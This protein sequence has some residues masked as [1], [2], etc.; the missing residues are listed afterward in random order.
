MTC[1]YNPHTANGS[2]Y[3]L[4]QCAFYAINST[5][6]KIGN[7]LKTIQWRDAPAT[8]SFI[9]TQ[10]DAIN[11]I[12]ASMHIKLHHPSLPDRQ[13]LLAT[14]VAAGTDR[15]YLKMLSYASTATNNAVYDE[16]TLRY[17]SDIQR[18]GSLGFMAAIAYLENKRVI[19]HLPNIAAAIFSE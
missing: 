15:I 1:I 6:T 18:F 2:A 8:L 4:D 19:E 16:E 5:A 11:T 10:I 12:P 14:I 17:H 3:N 9:N 13:L 7:I